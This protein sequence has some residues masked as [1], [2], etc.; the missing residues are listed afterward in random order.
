[1]HYIFSLLKYKLQEKLTS[2]REFNIYSASSST[3]SQD[4]KDADVIIKGCLLSE[5][6][7]KEEFLDKHITYTG[8]KDYM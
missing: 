4:L 8:A 6:K 7:V 3:S 1:M 2:N 5:S